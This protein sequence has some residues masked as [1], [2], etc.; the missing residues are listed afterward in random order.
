MFGRKVKMTEADEK[1]A[2]KR[3]KHGG[4]KV[5]HYLS[6]L[7]TATTLPYRPERCHPIPPDSR[8]RRRLGKL[9]TRPGPRSHVIR[10]R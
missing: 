9:P 10:A 6:L 2:R 3:A 8:Q 1:R 7:T 4:R 5:G